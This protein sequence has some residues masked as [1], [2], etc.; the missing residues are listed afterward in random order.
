MKIKMGKSTKEKILKNIREGLMSPSDHP[1]PNM[2]FEQAI[3]PQ[4]GESLDLLFAKKFIENHKGQFFYC[5]NPQEFI[6][7][8]KAL[9]QKRKWNNIYCKD[10]DIITL[11][12]KIGFSD[13]TTTSTKEKTD[14]CLMLPEALLAQTGSFVITSNQIEGN[15][16]ITLP[17]TL[18]M[19]ASP[20]HIR[21][22]LKEGLDLIKKKYKN[23][24]SNI[25]IITGNG[26]QDKIDR[27]TSIHGPKE[28]FL[29]LIDN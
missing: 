25:S 11:F 4:T 10:N 18:I 2:D 17:D 6:E 7:H 13:F 9:L 26:Q 3:F 22:N 28:L 20:Q 21:G 27:T 23:V 24:P 12:N 29:F 14:V 15:E 1:F 16:F 5:G 8:L 19:V